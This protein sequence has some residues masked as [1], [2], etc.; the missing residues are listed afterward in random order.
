MNKHKWNSLC[1]AL[2][3]KNYNYIL[4]KLR[5]ILLFFYN[6]LRKE[7]LLLVMFCFFAIA[8]VRREINWNCSHLFYCLF[9]LIAHENLSNDM[10]NIC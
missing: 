1:S 6:I 8:C 5:N 3:L 4:Y 7:F 10:T 9:D 2:Y